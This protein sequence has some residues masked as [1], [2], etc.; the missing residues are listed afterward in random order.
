[1]RAN[2]IL[3]AILHVKYGNVLDSEVF[4]AEKS[5]RI[6][7]KTDQLVEKLS[8]IGFFIIAKVSPV[9][10]M[11]PKTIISYYIYFTTD[12]GSDSFILPQLMM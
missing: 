10:W 2:S 9:L 6:Y 12:S 5:K 7:K 8:D 1:M 4:D 3:N 11:T